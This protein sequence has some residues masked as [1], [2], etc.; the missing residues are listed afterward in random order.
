MFT[1]KLPV[2]PA[3]SIRI[4]ESAKP[5]IL[6]A[7][8]LPKFDLLSAPDLRLRFECER[9]H[10]ATAAHHRAHTPPPVHR[11][12]RQWDL[13]CCPD[14][15]SSLALQS[16]CLRV[17]S[18]ERVAEATH[19]AKRIGLASAAHRISQTIRSE[20]IAGYVTRPDHRQAGCRVCSRAD[21][22]GRP[23]SEQKSKYSKHISS[24]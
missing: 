3:G 4:Q 17:L 15:P 16:G 6:A 8:G 12:G 21:H 9:G 18:L 2:Q 13:V 22:I 10:R 7:T 19:R 23:R 11:S 24:H 20:S 14:C 5:V 1:D